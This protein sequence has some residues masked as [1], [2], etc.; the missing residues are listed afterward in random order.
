VSDAAILVLLA[1][2]SGS[3]G[4]QAASGRSADIEILGLGLVARAVLAARRAGFGQTLLIGAAAT[5]PEAVSVSSWAE[6]AARLS[7]ARPARLAIAPATILAEAQWL[8]QIGGQAAQPAAWAAASRRLVL[9]SADKAPQALQTLAARGAADLPAVEAALKALFGPAE[10]LSAEIDP[11]AIESPQDRR[12]AERRLLGSLVKPTDGFM[13][14]HVERPI[15]LQ[16]SRLLAPSRITPN[17]MSVISILVGIAGGPFFL[18]SRPSMQ[19]AGALLF[20]AHSILDG[21]DG[22]LARLK[23]QQSRLGGVL[24]FWGDNLVHAVIFA[25]MAVG[26]SLAI[27]ALWPLAFG[28]GAVFGALGSAGFVY[29]RVMRDKDGGESM[30]TSVSTAPER[31]LARTLD[32]ASRRDFIYLVVGLALFGKSNWF[33]LLAG[34]GAPIYGLLVVLLAARERRS[35][36]EG[37]PR[38]AGGA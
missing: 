9:L 33:L 37:Q 30:F 34:V 6:V 26:W 18:S 15:S 20:L 14:R 8:E 4:R 19:T 29:W 11:L 22:E 7:G 28:A 27:G 31:P 1:A 32:A 38:A 36:A 23:F 21:C 16:I 17:Q 3:L 35:S 5:V 10:P 13:A 24:D 2:P 12:Q 25:C